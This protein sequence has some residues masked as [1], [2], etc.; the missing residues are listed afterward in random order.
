MTTT[1]TT[2]KK[3]MV[4]RTIAITIAHG[5]SG[6]DQPT[7]DTL[8][9][10]AR[11]IDHHCDAIGECGH[12]CTLRAGHPSETHEMYELGTTTRFHLVGPSWLGRDSWGKS[13]PEPINA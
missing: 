12:R 6:L 9:H 11:A 8:H 13:M 5:S 7:R 1:T 4:P 2:T 10:I 3:M